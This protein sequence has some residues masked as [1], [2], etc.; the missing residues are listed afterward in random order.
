MLQT[1]TMHLEGNVRERGKN[2]PKGGEREKRTMSEVV[3]HVG[4]GFTGL[5]VYA[6]LEINRQGYPAHPYLPQE[7]PTESSI[8]KFPFSSP[9]AHVR[10]TEKIK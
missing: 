1:E 8:S 4:G 6:R 3:F 10:A 2:V 5:C 9:R 7:V